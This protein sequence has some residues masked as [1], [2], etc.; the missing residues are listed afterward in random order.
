MCFPEISDCVCNIIVTE[1]GRTGAALRLL[2]EYLEIVIPFQTPEM[3]STP[4]YVFIS[5]KITAGYKE[6]L[7]CICLYPAL[8]R[9]EVTLTGCQLFLI[10][11]LYRNS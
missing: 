11:D 3:V 7:L 8:I 5:V 4:V 9:P 2:Q 10:L 1:V 6:P